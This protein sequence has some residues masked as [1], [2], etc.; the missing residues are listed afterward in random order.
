MK[1]SISV[2]DNRVAPVFDVSKSFMIFE[3]SDEKVLNKGTFS[4]NT[5]GCNE[6]IEKLKKDGVGII[7]CG[8]VS[9]QLL[10]S[11]DLSGIKLI[12]WISGQV[13]DI[14]KAYRE[15]RLESASFFMPGC[16]RRLRRGQC[17]RFK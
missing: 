13:D 11:L 3:V 16:R 15:N 5:I 7:I 12:P 6:I 9:G 2:L 1:I 8:A 14:V 17:R 10:N 4:L